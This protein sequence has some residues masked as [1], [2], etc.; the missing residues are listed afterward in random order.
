MAGANTA[1]DLSAAGAQTIGGLSGT[2]NVTLGAS[3]LT[4]AGSA[5]ST[6]GG[7]ISGTG[8]LTKTGTGTQTLDGANLITGGVTIN[9]G[10]L[11]LGTNGSLAPNARVTV[12][13]GGV[14]DASAAQYQT[15]GALNGTGGEVKLGGIVLTLE[16]GLW[17]HDLG[18]L[19]RADE[20]RRRPA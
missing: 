15:L 8:T 17:R 19:R 1:F 14:F 9:G 5:S 10:T 2:G 7:V 3:A 6:Y 18:Q 13:T 16:S 12:D 4:L 20:D 11:K